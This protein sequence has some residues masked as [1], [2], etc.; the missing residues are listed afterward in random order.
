MENN[1]IEDGL[2]FDIMSTGMMIFST[3]VI[4]ANVKILVFSNTYYPFSI[5]IIF[6][7]I[8]FF[9]MNFYVAN[10]FRFFV[11]YNIFYR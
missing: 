3:A 10:I 7:S 4:L 6:G 8:G 11:S 1:F 9:I 5:L 2:N